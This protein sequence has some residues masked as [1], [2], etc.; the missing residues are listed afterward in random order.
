MFVIAPCSTQR[1][2]VRGSHAVAELLP[3]R[4]TRADG[5]KTPRPGRR[6]EGRFLERALTHAVAGTA[7]AL[8]VFHFFG[9]GDRIGCGWQQS[10]CQRSGIHLTYATGPQT[11]DLAKTLRMLTSTEFCHGVDTVTDSVNIL[12]SLG[13]MIPQSVLLSG[14]P[15]DRVMNRARS[16]AGYSGAADR[17]GVEHVFG[18]PARAG[19][20]RKCRT[21]SGRQTTTGLRGRSR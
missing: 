16:S 15:R 13:L 18:R 10:G 20:G 6:N 14:G 17:T 3:E 1:S 19:V 12:C 4:T 2:S 7:A 9:A 8:I 11:L 5:Q 21:S